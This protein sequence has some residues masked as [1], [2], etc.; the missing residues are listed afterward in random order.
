MGLMTNLRRSRD[1][2]FV[3]SMFPR[4]H[5][6]NSEIQP[7]KTKLLSKGSEHELLFA[8]FEVK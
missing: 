2:E 4:C 7:E 5:I 6:I 8:D 3:Q 1:M